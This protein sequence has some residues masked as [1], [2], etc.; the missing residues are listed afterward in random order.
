MKM[1][2]ALF[3]ILC[4][5]LLLAGCGEAKD[6]DEMDVTYHFNGITNSKRYEQTAH[7]P[8][9]AFLGSAES[10][11]KDLAIASF[12]MASSTEK[13]ENLAS[14]FEKLGF[15]DVS[16]SKAYQ[17][18]PDTAPL[19]AAYAFASK[20]IKDTN[21]LAVTIRGTNYGQEWAD[22]MNI[23]TEGDQAS[24]TVVSEE[25][26]TS[27][28]D[29]AKPYQQKGFRL[30][31]NG[32]SKAGALAALL[33]K[34]IL[35]RKEFSLDSKTLFAYTFEAPSSAKEKGNYPSIHNVR[36]P[37]DIVAALAP[38]EYGLYHPGV[39][40][41]LPVEK[42]KDAFESFDPKDLKKVSYK[43]VAFG[44]RLAP[45]AASFIK[46]GLAYLMEK[47]KEDSKYPL[48]LSTRKGWQENIADP[49]AYLLAFLLEQSGD[50]LSKIAGKFTGN[51]FS[52]LSILGDPKSFQ[53]T[54]LAAL[55]EA[56]LAYDSS[57]M[58]ET[59][60]KLYPLVAKLLENNYAGLSGIISNVAYFTTMHCP[61]TI[62]AL[63]LA[64]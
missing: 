11:S 5:A 53:E 26:L 64:S 2:R 59:I 61:E 31:V 22:N 55:D 19:T 3:S 12:A 48:D 9:N 10:Y 4:S 57:K 29:Y 49:L 45:D 14:F 30:W 42:L 18:E 25:I 47:P 15:A 44:E 23:G 63:L 62:C 21:V 40:H 32:Y 13:K 34:K 50:V 39:E 43:G 27:L 6:P 17:N 58:S 7:F 8:G 33:S 16:W 24:Y 20:T 56:K 51:L 38:E 35:D 1:K 54:F 28:K 46:Q 60:A 37:H 41:L 36:N 52:L